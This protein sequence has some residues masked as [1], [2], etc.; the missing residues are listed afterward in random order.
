VPLRR[1]PF[2]G[3]AVTV[4]FLARRVR[5]TVEEMGDGGRRLVVVTEDGE[6]ITFV[7]S[8]AT[9]NFVEEGRAV[10]GARL[11]FDEP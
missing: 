9:G 3:A 6:P 1:A 7:L 2:V 11:T 8:P 10:G 5:A 4:V